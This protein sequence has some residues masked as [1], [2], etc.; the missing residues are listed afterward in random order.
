MITLVHRQKLE[1]RRPSGN[2][3]CTTGL[4]GGRKYRNQHRDN[5]IACRAS[6]CEPES[7]LSVSRSFRY[8]LTAGMHEDADGA[9][10]KL[11]VIAAR[12]GLKRNWMSALSILTACGALDGQTLGEREFNIRLPSI[13]TVVS[14]GRRSRETS[15]AQLDHIEASRHIDALR[16]RLFQRVHAEQ[17]RTAEHGI[18]VG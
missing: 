12:R 18:D 6:V 5:H 16:V 15:V 1:R 2:H 3:R 13:R 8:R 17:L 9:K 4:A 10:Q 7:L 11:P 14:K